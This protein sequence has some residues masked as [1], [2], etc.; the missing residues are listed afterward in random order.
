MSDKRKHNRCDVLVTYCWNRVG[1]N[2]LRSLSARGL[3]RRHFPAQHM[4]YVEIL[5]GL[6]HVS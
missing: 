5:R 1:Y 2:I 6:V 3:V 4:Q